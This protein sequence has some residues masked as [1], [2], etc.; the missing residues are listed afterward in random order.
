[1]AIW[2]EL[3]VWGY[4]IGRLRN[5]RRDHVITSHACEHNKMNKKKFLKKMCTSTEKH[6]LSML[7][8]FTSCIFLFVLSHST[9]G[10]TTCNGRRPDRTRP[11]IMFN[12]RV[13][14]KKIF[15]FFLVFLFFVVD[16]FRFFT[17]KKKLKLNCVC[18]CSCWS[19]W[20]ESEIQV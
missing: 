16:G 3:I 18:C 5:E 2:A 4:F 8:A 14:E 11:K 19:L 12:V 6:I 7:E 15:H 13:S 1:M 10:Q 17:R 9:N 20:I